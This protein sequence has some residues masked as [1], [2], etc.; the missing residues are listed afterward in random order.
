MADTLKQYF[1][2]LITSTTSQLLVTAGASG[3]VVRTIHLANQDTTTRTVSISLGVSSAYSDTTAI[4]QTFSIPANGVHVWNGSL[5]LTASQ[6]LYAKADV[7]SKVVAAI[8][9]VDL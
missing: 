4:Y 1:W 5:V 8:S 3:G 7:G 6:T 2:G 9:G